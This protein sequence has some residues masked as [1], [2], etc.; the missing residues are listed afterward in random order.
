MKRISNFG[1]KL[2]ALMLALILVAG[3]FAA[4]P[5][6][7]VKA[8]D[9]PRQTKHL[10]YGYSDDGV[11]YLVNKDT[12]EY[13][14]N[15][16][17]VRE[18]NRS[19]SEGVLYDRT[20]KKTVYNADQT[21]KKVMHYQTYYNEDGSVN[22]ESVSRDLY[23]YKDGKISY[24][25]RTDQDGWFYNRI[26]YKYYDDGKIY[27]ISERDPSDG[28]LYSYTRYY[29]KDLEDGGHR[30]IE[31]EYSFDY[32]LNSNTARYFDAAGNEVKTVVTG[33]YAALFSPGTNTT[34]VTY[35]EYSNPIYG[36][37][38]SHADGT[39]ARDD[40]KTVTT[41]K[42]I[43]NEDHTLNRSIMDVSL[44]WGGMKIESRYKHYYYWE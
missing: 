12:W 27:Q 2:T 16:N 15:G 24:I 11:K 25:K 18:V 42:N 38:V 43:Y 41:Y 35:D 33:P 30:V 34:E 19:Y 22:N 7:S 10:L 37:Y 36:Y 32:S 26:N 14:A 44:D 31:L 28:S 23:Y 4:I 5:K 8:A 21:V 3:A 13:D 1:R 20:I 40:I 9:S 6:M 17:I 39:S 29:Y